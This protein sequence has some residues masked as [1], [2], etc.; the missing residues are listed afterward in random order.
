MQSYHLLRS[1]DVS[2]LE[3]CLVLRA[4]E[5]PQP[6]P[7]EALVRV[8]AASLNYRDIL[9][10]QGRYPVPAKE[11]VIPLSD[12]AGQ[13]IA[14]GE[15]VSRV[16]VGDKVAA[17]YFTR[18]FDGRLTL[19][20]ALRQ[21]G[22]SDEGMLAQYRVLHEDR[23]VKLPA[24][25][26]FGEGA[27]LTCAALTAWSCLTGPRPVLPGETVLTG[28]TGG[29]ALFALQFAKVFGARTIALA[30]SAAKA[31][32]LRELG[33][34]EVIPYREIPEWDAEVRR[35]TGGAGA[36]HVVDSV[37]VATLERS[38][39]A[40]AF[41]GEIAFPGAFGS[42]DAS[43]DPRALAGRLVNIRR[44]AVGSRAAF[45]AM[46]RAIAQHQLHPVI[47]RVFAFEEAHAAY[48]HYA[49]QQHV[50]KVVISLN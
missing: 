9:L 14:V 24:H 31:D 20:L 26:S 41:G 21:T 4:Q 38:L 12:G 16:A 23:L 50:G 40:A 39:K 33:A 17:T 43:F 2:S 46:N 3:D 1:G 47:G 35:L 37:G 19:P 25:L 36:D 27:T 7:G 22:A 13:V 10:L 28:G 15:G 45:E 34:D 11:A 6:G 18:W 49:A 32:K 29:L 8:R 30:S 5:V 48:R 44:V 42:P